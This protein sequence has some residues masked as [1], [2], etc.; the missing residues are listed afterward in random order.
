MQWNKLASKAS[1][2]KTINAL[3]AAGIESVVVATSK[4]AKKQVLKLIPQKSEVMQMTSVTLDSTE[5]AHEIND[6]GKYTSVRNELMKMDR[7][8]DNAKMQKL[9]AAPDWAVG[10]VHAV[11][12]EGNV[13]IASMTGSQLPAYASGASHVIWVVGTQKIVENLDK[14][15]KRIYEYVLPAR[16]FVHERHTVCRKPLPVM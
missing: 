2:N 3:K 10:S 4:D 5:I 6:S 14:A 7:T 8:K 9:G 11:T 13:V 12:E 15:M 16:Q 1:L